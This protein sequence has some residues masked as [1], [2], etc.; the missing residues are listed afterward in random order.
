MF[1]D[2]IAGD[3][4]V[5]RW[6]TVEAIR[7]L[8]ASEVRAT[9]VTAYATGA[10]AEAFFVFRYSEFLT[11][12]L[13]RWLRGELPPR[14]TPYDL[15]EDYGR[16][17]A[18]L[19]RLAAPVPVSRLN[20]QLR[21]WHVESDTDEETLG[22]RAMRR[23]LELARDRGVQVLVLPAPL[24][25]AD[26]WMYLQGIDLDR[27]DQRVAELCRRLG[28]AFVARQRLPDFRVEDFIDIAHL[29][30]RGRA[31]YSVWLGEA[32][33]RSLLLVRRDGLQ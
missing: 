16:D 5:R 30:S 6:S 3:K 25:P 23:F 13:A 11:G 31:T 19:A 9:E 14:P 17:W 27:V 8:R 1:H 28:A 24:N 33:A 26:R 10:F 21:A 18:M 2:S 12:Q 7:L 20:R 22:W 4:V 29:N 32:I 15:I